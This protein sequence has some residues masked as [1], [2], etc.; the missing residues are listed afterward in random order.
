MQEAYYYKKL[1]E[2]EER[3]NSVQEVYEAGKSEVK[4]LRSHNAHPYTWGMV[5]SQNYL[6]YEEKNKLLDSEEN[7]IITRL[8]N[9]AA[10]GKTDAEIHA[11]YHKTG[12]L[13]QLEIAIDG[14]DNEEPAKIKVALHDIVN[15]VSAESLYAF[16][17]KYVEKTYEVERSHEFYRH[18]LD[19]EGGVRVIGEGAPFKYMDSISP[20]SR[21]ELTRILDK[22]PEI[23]RIENHVA[24][25][26]KEIKKINEQLEA[27]LEARFPLEEERLKI[28]KEYTGKTYP[29]TVRMKAAEPTVKQHKLED[30]DE[31][32]LVKRDELVLKLIDEL[33]NSSVKS[34]AIDA[35]FCLKSWT[36]TCNRLDLYLYDSTDR[37]GEPVYANINAKALINRTEDR[38]A[39]DALLIFMDRYIDTVYK[40]PEEGDHT[41]TQ[42][43]LHGNKDDIKT[44]NILFNGSPMDYLG[45]NQEFER[46]LSEFKP[47]EP[48]KPKN[49]FEKFMQRISPDK[50][51]DIK[52]PEI[53]EKEYGSVIREAIR[54]TQY[55]FYDM[56]REEVIQEKEAAGREMLDRPLSEKLSKY[57]EYADQVE[58]MLTT[59]DDMIDSIKEDKQE[60]QE[61]NTPAA[62]HEIKDRYKTDSELGD[63]PGGR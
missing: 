58:S 61:N 41:Y 29:E 1:K 7:N 50:E 18:Y 12:A 40:A 63:E 38:D 27:N 14:K 10:A 59:L 2:I 30:K 11:W 45:R 43:Y 13:D 9:D 60:E 19:Q 8:I 46:Q 5:E 25:Y 39:R 53:V 22:Q 55:R 48:E 32:L 4:R 51:Q 33:G 57:G 42:D 23:E 52:K 62:D 16:M 47:K 37:N 31:A 34:N 17:N 3:K 26:L 36:N 20:V 21:R 35:S 15:K 44:E 54:A 49:L 28:I 56:K 24:S 6:D